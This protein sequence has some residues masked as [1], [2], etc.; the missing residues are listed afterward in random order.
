M[1]YEDIRNNLTQGQIM[2][3]FMTVPNTYFRYLGLPKISKENEQYFFEIVVNSKRHAA[4][5]GEIQI[6]AEAYR[7]ILSYMIGEE[8]DEQFVLGVLNTEYHDE[9]LK[10][11]NVAI[12]MIISYGRVAKMVEQV[13]LM[14][15]DKTRRL[16]VVHVVRHHHAYIP[17]LSKRKAYHGD[18]LFV[19]FRHIAYT[20][21][22]TPL[23]AL[24]SAISKI[25]DFSHIPSDL[26]LEQ[27]VQ[28]H[29][30]SILLRVIKLGYVPKLISVPNSDTITE[31][32]LAIILDRANLESRNRLDRTMGSLQMLSLFAAAALLCRGANQ[33]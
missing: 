26:A 16:F 18:M 8:S 33:E 28:R 27:H 12:D 3:V 11:F 4:Y 14:K 20:F 22:E 6:V 32:E 1:E 21:A 24:Y 10:I 17:E 9:Y 2:S 19:C 31:G 23:N 29:N 15:D 13:S 5:N 30:V 7:R 25:S